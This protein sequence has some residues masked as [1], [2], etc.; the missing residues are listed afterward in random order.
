VI[1]KLDCNVM[2]RPAWL[3]GG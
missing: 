2:W 1:V 3:S